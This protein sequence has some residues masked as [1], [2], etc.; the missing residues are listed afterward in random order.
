MAQVELK[1]SVEELLDKI[2]SDNAA[3]FE[4]LATNGRGNGKSKK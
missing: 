2:T 1:K 3:L 4:L